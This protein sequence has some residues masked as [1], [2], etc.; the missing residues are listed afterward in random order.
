MKEFDMRRKTKPKLEQRQ[1]I[2]KSNTKCPTQ[3]NR[4]C[5]YCGSFI[6]QVEIHS[7]TAERKPFQ[8]YMQENHL[9]LKCREADPYMRC[10]KNV[11]ESWQNS[12]DKSDTKIDTVHIMSLKFL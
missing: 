5:G 11:N 2:N 4:K 6:H 9:N 7:P 8:I 10:N 1:N 3:S 12:G